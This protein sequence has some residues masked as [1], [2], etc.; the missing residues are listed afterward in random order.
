VYL[1]EVGGWD[2]RTGQ[3]VLTI[4][5]LATASPESD[6]GDAPDGGA[7]P[8]TAYPD[9]GLG[10]VQA[11]FPTVFDDGDGQPRGPVHLEPF[12]VA[13][14]GKAVTLEIEADTGLDE[15]GVNNIDRDSDLA[16]QDGA[17]D[18]VRLPIALTHCEWASFDYVVNVITPGTDLWVNAWLDFNRDGDWDDD[19]VTDPKMVCND[20]AY[21]SEWSVR[22]Q[23]LYDLPEGLHQIAA[24]AFLAWHPA[25]GP[26]EIWMRIT[27]SEQPW[28]GGD[29]PGKLGNGGSGPAEG[30]EIGET[31]DYLIVPEQAGCAL[32]E[33]LN[34]DGEIDF[35][36]LIALIYQWLDCCGY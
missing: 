7:K 19:S 23:Y 29:S 21:I 25:K 32:C 4:S 10:T 22:N 9:S 26:E 27:L 14:L 12:A 11:H 18:G 20:G 2:R 24:P 36:D 3:G 31:E 8:M 1:V 30:Y 34:G 17:D 28:K 16:D 13:H 35:D 33:D 15:D 5:L 6:L